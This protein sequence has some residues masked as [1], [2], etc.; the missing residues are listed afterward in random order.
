M[1]FSCVIL[2][3]ES[4]AANME[5]KAVCME[6]RASCME[7]RVSCIEARV[8]CMEVRASCVPGEGP[9]TEH[10]KY[11]MHHSHSISGFRRAN[12]TQ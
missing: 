12:F 11:K 7:A 5:A 10:H 9:S 3:M 4:R 2:G 8:S 6:D 1:L